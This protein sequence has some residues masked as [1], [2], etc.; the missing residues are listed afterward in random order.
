MG[1]D[2]YRGDQAVKQVSP[3]LA[4]HLAGPVTTLA[5]CWS[6]LRRDGREFLFTDHDR[7]VLF[8]GKTYRASVGYS[9]TAISSDAQLAVDNLDIDGFL[10]DEEIT[11]Q[12]MRAGLFDFAEVRIFL[13]NWKAPSMGALRLRRGHLG[14][15]TLAGNG[16][17]RGE[18]RGMTQRLQ[19][20]IGELYSAE[21]RADLGDARC[22]VPVLPPVI[23][24]STGYAVGDMVRVPVRSGAWP[25]GI[26]SFRCSVAGVTAASQPAYAEGLGAATVDGTATFVAEQAWTR[27]GMVESVTARATFTGAVEDA[28]MPTDGFRAGW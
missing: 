23:Q 25:Y 5:T 18:L 24:R 28:A 13:V 6:I 3:A 10:D 14:E 21:C 11:E 19:Q 12:D 22:R 27:P 26:M 8:D 9:R 20:E 17:F 15:V 7:D 1:P 16:M 2:P 4:A